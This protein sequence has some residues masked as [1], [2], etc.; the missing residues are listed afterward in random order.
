MKTK[1]EKKKVAPP[2]SHTRC[3][4][5]QGGPCDTMRVYYCWHEQQASNTHKR[6]PPEL[7]EKI[8]GFHTF[9]SSQVYFFLY[10][11]YIHC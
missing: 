4:V 2:H 5:T 3:R 11:G 7:C 6:Q 1:K 8:L 10:Y 9:L